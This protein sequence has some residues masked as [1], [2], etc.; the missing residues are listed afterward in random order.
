MAE[1]HLS[2]VVTQSQSH[3]QIQSH[4]DSH[5]SNHHHPPG[6]H[7]TTNNRPS[8]HPAALGHPLFG[9]M[10][11]IAQR[12]DS[13]AAEIDAVKRKLSKVE[14]TLTQVVEIQKELKHLIEKNSEKS[15][16]IDNTQYQV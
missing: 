9:V 15:F 7:P 5:S 10:D 14:E 6:R 11:Y 1:Q 8:N 16:S 13:Q 3:S 2:R 12:V 4:V